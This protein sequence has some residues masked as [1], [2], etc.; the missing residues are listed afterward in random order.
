MNGRKEQIPS[1]YKWMNKQKIKF[2]FQIHF[3]WLGD[4][5]LRHRMQGRLILVHLMCRD[6]APFQTENV[7][8]DKATGILHFL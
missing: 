5:D 6:M 2:N 1:D 7:D 4:S 8:E 3:Q